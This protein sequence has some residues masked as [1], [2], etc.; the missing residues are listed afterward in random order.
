MKHTYSLNIALALLLT[1]ALVF[2]LC[3]CN[4]SPPEPSP[5]ETP[6]PDE[7][8]KPPESVEYPTLD[9]EPFVGYFSGFTSESE[10]WYVGTTGTAMGLQYNYIFLTHDGGRTWEETGNLNDVWLK[11]LTCAVFADD[12]TGFLCYRY[13]VENIGRVYRTEDGGQTWTRLEIPAVTELLGSGGVG[14]VRDIRVTGKNRL[15]MTYYGCPERGADNNAQ[16]QFYTSVS[17]DLGKTWS[18]FTPGA[19]LPLILSA[20]KAVLLGQA[21]LFDTYAKKN[22]NISQLAQTVT[23]DPDITVEVTKFALIDLDHDGTP[24]VVLWLAIGENDSVGFEVLRYQDGVVYCY[25]FW[26]RMFYNLKADGTFWFSSGASDHGFGSITFE[27]DT[28]SID[29]ITYC[30]TGSYG[31]VT[32]FVNHQ[33]ATEK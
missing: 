2:T 26:Y 13:D 17:T 22:M 6:I 14:E 15:E 30:E 3:A 25:T 33:S 5:S 32:Y 9:G 16:G 29:E 4:S 8:P 21:E 7:S 20:Y 10:G 28:C 31:N 24:E 1:F 11:V 19:S 27:K 12:K 23:P 18:A